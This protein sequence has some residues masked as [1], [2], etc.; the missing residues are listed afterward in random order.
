MQ[1]CMAQARDLHPTLS[2]TRRS[3]SLYGESKRSSL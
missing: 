3:V 1:A 2:S